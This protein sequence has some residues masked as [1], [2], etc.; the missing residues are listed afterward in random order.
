MN[1]RPHVKLSPTGKTRVGVVALL[2]MISSSSAFAQA[3]AAPQI[4]IPALASNLSINP[5]RVTFA[6]LGKAATIS[7][8]NQGATGRF[9]VELVDRIMLPDGQIIAA[10]DAASKPELKPELDRLK[11]A[12]AL[13]ITTPRRLQLAA[14]S[15]Q[16]IRVRAAAT[17]DVAPG[18]YRTHLTVTGLPPA[19]AGLTADDAAAKAPGQLS[20]RINSVLGISIPVIIRVG[21]IDV[22]AGIEHAAVAV[23]SVS[24]DG[25]AA[26][27]PT[28]ILS[29]ELVRQ[30]PNSLFGDLEIRGAKESGS[31]PPLGIVRS[32]GVYPEIERRF[33][34]IPLRR[35]PAAGERID[36]QFRDDDI[37]PGAVLAKVS[38]S[39]P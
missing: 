5:K 3:A 14:S 7:V 26:P 21:A 4:A 6:G 36:I 12:K 34:K 33:V 27:V 22:R 9:D 17:A 39:A 37:H 18:E 32:I 16:V 15:G 23:E 8:Y 11:S 24:P 29:L 31:Q 10:S 35:I 1:D 2:A 30:G 19:D 20:F 38:L 25:R 28:A 13:I